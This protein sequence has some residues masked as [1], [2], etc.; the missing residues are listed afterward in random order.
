MGSPSGPQNATKEA[1]EAQLER[2][3]ASKHIA[4]SASLSKLLSFLVRR[5]LEGRSAELKEY[6]VGV[7][8]FDR[9]EQFDPRIDSIVR[10]QSSKLRSRLQEYYESSGKNDPLILELPRGAYVPVWTLRSPP[11][12][13]AAPSKA[14][15]FPLSGA[16]AAVATVVLIAAMILAYISTRPASG[17]APSLASPFQHLTTSTGLDTSPAF[18]P[19]GT[20]IAYASD[21]SGGNLDIWVRRVSGDGEFQLTTSDTDDAEP[22]FS[23]DGKWIAFRSEEKD[24]GI[25]V[26]RSTGGS[27]QLIAASGRRPRFSPDGKW[28]AYWA[29]FELEG[30]LRGARSSAMYVVP[31]AGGPPQQVRPEFLAARYPTWSP[32]GKHLLFVGVEAQAGPSPDWYVQEV[33][34]NTVSRT[35]AAEVFAR[36]GIRTPIGRMAPGEWTAWGVLFSGRMGDSTNLWWLRLR[37]ESPWSA[38]DV[39]RLTSGTDTQ[40]QP[41]AARPTADGTLP[42]AIAVWRENVDVWMARVRERGAQGPASRLTRDGSRDQSGQLSPDGSMMA[43]LS[44]RAGTTQLWLKDM[45]S[46]TEQKLTSMADRPGHFH[47]SADGKWIG[48]TTNEPSRPLYRIAVDGRGR[49]ERLCVQCG[50]VWHWSPDNRWIAHVEGLPVRFRLFD[51]RTGERTDALYHASY[52]LYLPRFSPDGKWLLFLARTGPDRSRI[53]VARFQPGKPPA[54]ADWI[55]VTPDNTWNDKPAWSDDGKA[56]YFTSDRDGFRCLWKQAVMPD[57]KQ[58]TGSA[59]PVFHSHEARIS[60]ANAFDSLDLNVRGDTLVFEQGER[61]G[62]IWISSFKPGQ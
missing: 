33:A 28:I 59:I 54:E 42:I 19:D 46:G 41:A 24:G 27:P 29:G 58:P 8:V 61:E 2:I 49:P 37:G 6:V 11:V 52:Q 53:C 30:H 45:R 20:L 51:R 60:I 55:T 43:F 39:T 26:V 44:D 12:P 36:A 38:V 7:E 14:R 3:L 62:S 23:P 34:T 22:T 56:V 5:T 9:G 16:A 18:S 57:S 25:Y 21:R 1:V 4:S 13:A 10:V 47:F 32:D 48:F 17:S 31:A 50:L 35:G 40:V 15:R